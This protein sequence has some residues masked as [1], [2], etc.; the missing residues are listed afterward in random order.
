MKTLALINRVIILVVMISSLSLSSSFAQTS[1]PAVPGDAV[2]GDDTGSP[3]PGQ[4]SAQ[5]MLEDFYMERHSGTGMVRFL[6]SRVGGSL[7]QPK[8]LAAGASDLDAA[9][10]F[11]DAYGELFGLETPQQQLQIMRAQSLEDGRSFLRFQQVHANLPV[12]GGELIVQLD[13]NQ[14]VRSIQGEI[15][16]DVQVET[17]AHISP[18]TAIETAKILVARQYGYQ[19]EELQANQ[20]EL[21]LYDPI[22]IGAPGPRGNQLVWRMEITAIQGVDVR[23]LVLVNA[24]LGNVSLNFTQIDSAKYRL[25]Y[26][27]N[28]NHTLGLPGDGPVRSEGSAASS[29]GD[30]DRA[31]EYAGA[32]Y[33]F[34]SLYHLR[35][36]IDNKGMKLVSTVNYC[37]S[38]SSCPFSNAFWNGSQMVYG[39]GYAAADDVVAHEL[40]HGVTEHESG[41]FYY[42]QSG[43]INEALS[44]IWG[45]L[46]DLSYHGSYDNDDPGVRWLLGEDLPGSAIR[47]MSNPPAFGDPDKI[48]SP[49]Y[50]CGANDGGGVHTN[51]GVANKAA[52]LMVDGGAFNGYSISG[53]GIPKTIHIWY[54]VQTNLLTSASDYQDLGSALLLACSNLRGTYGITDSD[55]NQ[56]SKAT[57]AVEMQRLPTPCAASDVLKCTSVNAG[58]TFN[59]SMTGWAT[60]AGTWQTDANYLYSS[61][62]ANDVFASTAFTQK[63]FGDFEYKVSL[64]RYGNNQNSNGLMIRGQ[65]SPL[66][67]NNRWHS[68]YG[69]YYTRDGQYAVFRY[70]NGVGA[71]L[72]DW[73]PHAAIL[74][75]DSWNE[76]KVVAQEDR[77]D[78]YINNVLV[79]SGIDS[80]YRY[81]VNGIS[82]FRSLGST[83]DLLQAD[84]AYTNGGTAVSLFSD[85]FENP[86]RGA[87]Y[88]SAA[89]GANAWHY[90]QTNNPYG[91]DATYASSGAYNLWGYN[92]GS[93]S[94]SNITLMSG[95]SIPATSVFMAFK[96]AYAFEGNSPFYDGGVLE[97][98]AN[99]GPWLD[100]GSLMIN[101]A[102]PP[103]TISSSYG[104]PLAGRAAFIG[105]S[106][107]MITTRL[108]LSSLA[109]NSL[110]FRFRIG[111]DS[112]SDN[113]GWFIDD[114]DIF[115]CANPA[116]S[117]YLPAII[118]GNALSPT[119]FHSGFNGSSTPW[120]PILGNWTTTSIHYKAESPISNSWGSSSYSNASFS[121][122]SYTAR[123]KRAGCE[124]C[125]NQLIV[126]GGPYPLASG[127][128]WANAYSF[129]YTANGSFSVWKYQ[130]GV[131]TQIVPWTEHAAILKGQTWN[132]LQVVA[133][134][135]NLQFYINQVLVWSGSDTTFSSGRVGV[136]YYHSA[137]PWD[138]L[139]V[140]WA[141][142]ANITT[143]TMDETQPVVPGRVLPGGSPEFSPEP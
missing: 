34:F 125:T 50:Y 83:G 101:N 111:S 54:E 27:N 37:P 31:Y 80:T 23:E 123:L 51:S 65:P 24:Q 18:E 90:P 45:E 7:L 93:L 46:V 99:G 116:G 130:N 73:Q 42:M 70:D 16:P 88:S 14:N 36:S 113:L 72:A 26:N 121:N 107:G 38:S 122:F 67:A 135:S 41:L 22:L 104:N 6:T 124:T 61:G 87:W 13:A 32:T 4:S 132:L 85:D 8:P 120:T 59:G 128:Q 2:P 92:L 137:T 82:M 96:H 81:G 119:N 64:R 139:S 131:E 74:S 102:Y 9:L 52:A 86:V 114:V 10:N 77:L 49:N 68:G 40:T 71:A 91:Y 3:D 58:S 79:W 109:G 112:I 98:S 28:N 25:I 48:S 30:V 117:T 133:I 95:V 108:N 129:H 35:D 127:N 78:F 76:L 29:I 69:F 19:A 53:I 94:D 62:I 55:C 103:G 5:S 33:D 20:P 110:R 143:L 44:D 134:G 63:S 60:I 21:S 140:D 138:V 1:N 136:G 89:V 12:I 118:K 142:L 115:T 66:G 56:V 17:Q 11:L 15:L 100:A 105:Q 43:A 97:Y 39:Q 57:A 106:N 141:Q 47:S 75:G 126:R 84:W